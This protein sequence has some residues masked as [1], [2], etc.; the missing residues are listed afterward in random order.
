MDFEAYMTARRESF[1]GRAWLFQ[2]IQQ[3]LRS[4]KGSRTLVIK[5]GPGAG[6]SAFLSEYVARFRGRGVL[7]WHFCQHDEPKTLE[8]GGL[9]RNIAAQLA[10][11]RPAMPECRD[12]CAMQPD[13]REYLDDDDDSDPAP[14]LET[15]L[16][17]LSQLPRPQKAQLLVVDALDL[18]LQAPEDFNLVDLLTGAAPYFPDWLR[19]L[20]TTR[21]APEVL[22]PL[23]S[24][25]EAQ[26][27][28]LEGA[29][30]LEDLRQHV[31][32]RASR[33]DLQNILKAQGRSAELLAGLLRAKSGGMFLFVR[34]GLR[35][36]ASGAVSIASLEEM[37]PDGLDALYRLSLERRFSKP[38]EDYA[39]TR[40]VLGVLC[41]AR[42]PLATFELAQILGVPEQ[43]VR[44][45][46]GQLADFIQRRADGQQGQRCLL[47]VADLAFKEWLT[48]MKAGQPRA[49][50]FA[51][52]LTD[53][54]S[55][56]HRWALDRVE[57]QEAH[58]SPYLLRHLAWHLK[59]DV[60]REAVYAQL[61]LKSL[62]WSQAQLEASGWHGLLGD[63]VYI[64]GLPE[65]AWLRALIRQAA[66]ALSE[67]AAH[68][69]AQVLGRLG[70]GRWNIGLP[71]LASAAQHWAVTHTPTALLPTRRSL[72][73]RAGVQRRLEGQSPILALPDG[74]IA[75]GRGLEVCVC[76][77]GGRAAPQLL[78]GH[79]GGITGLA[80]LPDG[81]VVSG[82]S[83]QS[84]R[85]WNLGGSGVRVLKVH[86][87]EITSLAALP[88]DRVVFACRD[89][90]DVWVWNPAEA[91]TRELKGHTERVTALVVAPDGRVVSTG[92]DKRVRIWSL[93][94]APDQ[95]LEIYTRHDWFDAATWHITALGVR[96]DGRV[97]SGSE[98]GEV[99]LWSRTGTAEVLK[100]HRWEVTALAVLPD[101]RIVSGGCD[102]TLRVWNLDGTAQVLEGHGGKINALATMP[103]G[104]VVSGS[105]DQSV[106]IWKLTEAAPQVLEGHLWGVDAVLPL[107]DGDLV[108]GAESVRI[109]SLGGPAAPKLE[110]H[111]GWVSAL[112]LLPDG[113]VVSAGDDQT[114]RVWE[115]EGAT[116][117]LSRHTGSVTA[118][119]VLPD[120]R[121]VCG[122]DDG[123]I[124]VWS[125]EG[126]ATQLLQ[127]H[128]Q[129]VTALHVLPEGRVV[130]GSLDRSVRVW[131]MAGT[132][133]RVLEGHTSG[134]RALAAL[135]DGRVISAGDDSVARI[136]SLDGPAAQLLEGHTDWISAIAVLPDGHLV[137]ASADKTVRLWSLTGSATRR[138]EIGPASA[139]GVLPDGRLVC[140]SV[141]RSVRVWGRD[142][143]LQCAFVADG[144]ISCLAVNAAGLIVAGCSDGTVQ[145]LR[146]P[147][148]TPGS[149]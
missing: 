123:A 71:D 58:T 51:V 134:V 106:R 60:E 24:A 125:L 84:V 144:E 14:A 110:A 140:A 93:S 149:K 13:L 3:W 31:L 104:R 16:G 28:V 67:S 69:P 137:S 82:S 41:A 88:P 73:W 95:V 21:P 129:A 22:A 46:Q 105:A 92:A 35:E 101:G 57:R 90:N 80:A 133:P 116:R 108:T 120:G 56:L 38:V 103:D 138:L 20:I 15:L 1:T 44:A 75:F 136:W 128:T 11:P 121:V 98:T 53:G 126:A 47:S 37:P 10:K 4:K 89:A 145:M 55:R 76:D 81:R 54:R 113:R 102:H 109:W 94:G 40:E 17:R 66:P 130:S 6:K 99:R 96:P 70:V 147:P 131:D 139:L 32:E 86:S 65:A 8:P 111:I 77:P 83:D 7:A 143:E 119:A 36:L 122:C 52:G 97:I 26:Q 25:F 45:V 132:A 74:R 124:R 30:H 87:G 48:Q 112:A 148:D 64:R 59:D 50:R 34:D 117:L 118:L 114:L 62:P 78:R 135:P 85:V 146:V 12:P 39:R 127:G 18:A 5:A 100:G 61:L 19:L 49:A 29:D 42:E 9:V 68:W 72:P 27:I 107:R 91:T 141:G 79:T 43:Q 23:H 115:P 2:Q 142:F 33:E 63:V